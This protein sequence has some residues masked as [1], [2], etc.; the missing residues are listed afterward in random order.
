MATT[1]TP[2]REKE[3]TRNA[4][5]ADINDRR[6]TFSK[7]SIDGKCDKMEKYR[8]EKPEEFCSHCD[9]HV[10]QGIACENCNHWYHPECEK[11][12]PE[13]YE[14]LVKN[15]VTTSLWYCKIC[16]DE[17]AVLAEKSEA[18]NKDY[19]RMTK[20]REENSNLKK[21]N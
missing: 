21:E 17:L 13:E 20:W 4:K 10:N 7:V 1:R 9:L 14:F 11:V 19:K 16:R 12:S 5:D 6:K 3:I 18:L 15:Q 8:K 2:V